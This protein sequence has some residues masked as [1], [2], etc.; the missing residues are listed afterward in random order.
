MSTSP[1]PAQ[2]A[3]PPRR[4]AALLGASP[5]RSVLAKRNLRQ[6]PR[7]PELSSSSPRSSRSCS[8]CC[9]ATSSAARSACPGVELRQLPDARHLRADGR[10]SARTTTGIGLA[11]DLKKGLI[12]RFRSLPMAQVRRA[13]RPHDRRPGAQRVRRCI[14]MFVVGLARRLPPSDALAL[15]RSRHRADAARRLR[16]LLDLGVHR[17]AGRAA[18]RRCRRRASSGSSR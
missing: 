15:A 16:L 9:S 4:T 6:I 3:Q 18:S 13:D 17:P 1:P 14:V 8:C 10:S 11:E 12:D 2:T 7:I 5:T